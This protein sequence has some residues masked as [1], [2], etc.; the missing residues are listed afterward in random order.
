MFVTLLAAMA[1]KTRAGTLRGVLFDWD[2]TLLDS[3]HAD[4]HAFLAMFR[5]TGIAWG[6]EEL[7]RHYSPDWYRIYR[8]ARLPRPRWKEADRVWGKHYRKLKP[9]LLPGARR[10]LRELA[11]RYELGLVT[12]GDGPRI[13]RQLKRFRLANFFT[14]RVCGGDTRRRKP[15]PDP[16]LAA[17]R[18]M[19]IE[20]GACVYVG[21]APEDVEMA[22]RARVASIAVL[23]PFP[24]A[25]RLRAAKPEFLLPSI[26]QLPELLASL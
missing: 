2:G 25:T 26:E 9:A 14:A 8:A 10:V 16:L 19:R 13:R 18:H 24:V 22:R 11:N 3:F 4:S 12:S 15:H 17:L 7:E 6:M 20:P 1:R 23:G 5:E 21:D